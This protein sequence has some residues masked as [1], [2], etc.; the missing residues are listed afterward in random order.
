MLYGTPAL[1]NMVLIA[2]RIVAGL[3][4]S[5]NLQAQHTLRQ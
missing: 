3:Q 4:K 1:L 2:P 5:S